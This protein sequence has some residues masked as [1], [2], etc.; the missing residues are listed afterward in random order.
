MAKFLIVGACLASATA[1]AVAGYKFAERRL[2]EE[3]EEA[4]EIER[5]AIARTYAARQP[6]A[7]PQEAVDALVSPDRV[8]GSVDE[9]QPRE[10]V[11]Y[12]KIKPSSIEHVEEEVVEL[13]EPVQEQ[14]IFD[15]AVEEPKIFVISQLEFEHGTGENENV[16]LTWYEEDKILADFQDEKFD[17]PEDVIGDAIHRFGQDS[18]D[19]DTVYVRNNKINID[20]DISRHPGS[21]WR[22]VHNMEPPGPRHSKRGG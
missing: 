15:T 18:G 19:P 11:A 8:Q 21:Y 2:M 1:G 12:H 10:P 7:S 4:V 3:F 17:D 22:S 5:R 14:N 13:P 20:Y 16:S 6:Y 9:D